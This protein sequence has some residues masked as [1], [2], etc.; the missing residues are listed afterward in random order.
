MLGLTGFVFGPMGALL[1]SLFPPEVRYTG[2]AAA[3]SFG[4]ILGASL[5][6]YAAQVLVARG[7]LPWVGYYVSAA[8]L[9]SLAAAVFIRRR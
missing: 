4:G 6:P 8:G 7:G 5:A 9:V 3:Y 2:A 1:P